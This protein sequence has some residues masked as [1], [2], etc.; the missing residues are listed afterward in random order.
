MRSFSKDL[1]SIDDDRP[2][3]TDLAAYDF[4]GGVDE[5]QVPRLTSASLKKPPPTPM[6]RY[7][8]FARRGSSRSTSAPSQPRSFVSCASL[9]GHS[10]QQRRPDRMSA[11]KCQPCGGLPA[12]TGSCRCPPV[13][14]RALP[15][16]CIRLLTSMYRGMSTLDDGRHLGVCG[17][18]WVEVGQFF[19]GT[20]P[21]S[22][23]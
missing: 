21:R 20:R 19:D 12:T 18:A 9:S 6:G 1:V 11:A 13:T 7:C 23:T 8:E 3:T 22:L 14:Q 15:N 10:N 4:L 17:P 5:G 2:R 16:F